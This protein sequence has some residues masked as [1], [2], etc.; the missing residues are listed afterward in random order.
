MRQRPSSRLLVLDQQNKVLLFRFV[1]KDG[2]LAGKDFWATP[3]GE[4]NTGETFEEAAKRELFEETGIDIELNALENPV[5]EQQFI[6]PMPD[7]EQVMAHEKLYVVRTECQAIT[8]S[9]WTAL[10]MQVMTD[11]KWWSVMDLRATGDTVYPQDLADIL[12]K[13]IEE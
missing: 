4:V 12:I 7:G 8:N 2:A 1:F 5:A 11:H 10:E 3:G 13:V 6:L 9:N